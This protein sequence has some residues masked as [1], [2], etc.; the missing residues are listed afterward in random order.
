VPTSGG[1]AT[2]IAA[3]AGAISL[4]AAADGH[5]VTADTTAG[6]I[7][8]DGKVVLSDVSP[9]ALATDGK[10]LYWVDG[11]RVLAAPIAGGT[12][13]TL[14]AP[15]DLMGF[16]YSSRPPPSTVQLSG[17]H[18]IAAGPALPGIVQTE[19]QAKK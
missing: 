4:V 11:Q 9:D 13:E 18:V 10:Q 15:D 19:R 8:V 16:G 1:A 5:V 7:A 6:T 3:D 14:W 17:R 2:E 12:L